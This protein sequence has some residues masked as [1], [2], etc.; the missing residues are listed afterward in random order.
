MFYILLELLELKNA[1]LLKILFFFTKKL[2]PEFVGTISF[3]TFCGRG[4]R[5]E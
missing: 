1:F 3:H 5:G 2:E 4:C